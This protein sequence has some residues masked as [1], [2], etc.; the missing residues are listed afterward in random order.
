MTE[1]KAR[2]LGRLV[3]QARRA[4]GLTLRDLDGLTGV[5]Y[6]WLGKLEGGRIPAP[7]PSKL[8]KVAEVLDLPPERIDQIMRGQV[9][10]DLP[11]IRTY[12]RAKYNLKP[13]EIREIEGVFDRIQRSHHDH[14]GISG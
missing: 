13:E 2:Q 7:A 4:H 9:S 3:K 6:A 11:P 1:E 10:R 12:F 14:E 8:T 5:S